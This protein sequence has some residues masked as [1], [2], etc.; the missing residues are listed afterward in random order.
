MLVKE[1][2][3]KPL[4]ITE[5]KSMREAS[6][7]MAEHGFGCLIVTAVDDEHKV[8]GIITE[9]DVLKEVSKDDDLN[10]PLSSV[11]SKEV[12]TIGPE[13]HI[14]DA[15]QLMNQKKIKRLPVF[16]DGKLLGIITSTDLMANS[17]D[18]GEYS[19]FD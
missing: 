14:D 7:K 13:M 8:R 16:G 3:K 2:M 17:A 4:T 1:I 18:F 6:K 19:L 12:L 15:A 9:R 10:E 11:M 5:D